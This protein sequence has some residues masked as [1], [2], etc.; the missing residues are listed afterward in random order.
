[1]KFK[2]KTFIKITALL[3]CVLMILPMALAC[4]EKTDDEKADTPA[5]DNG[6]AAPVDNTPEDA[7]VPAV[8]AP[9]TDPPPTEAPTEP[10]DPNLPYYEYLA[11]EFA[12]FGFTGGDSIVADTEEEAMSLL[13]PKA[14]GKIELDV[15]GDG[16][17]FS[18]AYRY[19][20][21][22]LV[23]NFWDAAAELNFKTDKTLT[24]GDIIAGCIWVRDA[25][26]PNPA[27]LYFAYKTPTNDWGSEGDMNLNL[28][29]PGAKWEKI[30]FYGYAAVD[31]NP[32][33]QAMFNLF[34]GYEPHTID[35]GGLYMM[36]YPSTD[37]NEKAAYKLP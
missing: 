18:A 5:A 24:E 30:Y 4:G 21:T 17:P 3:L 11:A 28:V 16:V 33:S 35:I 9:P 6:T 15:S 25:K 37:A 27:Q 12:R 31:E 23:E 7:P 13:R 19:E 8:E 22:E 20:V 2:V 14:C 36:R 29:E 26:G 32:A 10:I 34:L 1:V